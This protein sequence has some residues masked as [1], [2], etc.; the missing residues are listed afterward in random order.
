MRRILSILIAL[1]ALVLTL[2]VP[3]GRAS[4]APY[5]GLVWGSLE[6]S[7]SNHS[8]APMTGIRS[9]RHDCFDR[10]VVDV[11]GPVTG[12]LVSYVDQVYMDASGAPVAL[13]GGAFLQVVVY[14]PAY[15]SD[16]NSTYEPG[17]RNELTDVTGYDTFRQVAWAG[18]FEGQT[19]VGLGVR[20]RLPFRVFTLDGPGSGSR[21]VVDVAHRW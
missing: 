10:M 7:S 13:R 1:S 15:D 4:A 8:T 12:Y 11:A 5:C 2:L 21:V 14:A 6:K 9:G 19:T 20:A 16:G 17:N 18:S 3:V